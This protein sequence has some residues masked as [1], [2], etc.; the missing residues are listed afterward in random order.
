MTYSRKLA[1]FVCAL[2]YD[3]VPDATRAR[4][5][6]LMTDTLGVGLSGSRHPNFRT[7]LEGIAAIPGTTGDHPVIGSRV[8]LSAPYAALANGVACHVL[9]FDD[10]HT[11]SIVH[12]SA[13]LTPLVLALGE[14]LGLGG[15]DVLTA[16]VAGW[17][18]AARI[19]IA[20]GN[21]FHSRGFHS[22]AIAGVFGATAAA[23]RL[24]GLTPEQ[25]TNALGLCG[26]QAAGI[27][28][29]LTN[30]SSSKGYHVGWAARTAVE[31]AYLARAG[32]TGPET[33]F[34]GRNGL[35]NTHGLVA[36][37]TPQ[38]LTAD[39]GTRWETERV[40]IKP[41]PCCHFAHG[42]IDCAIALRADGVTPDRIEGIH[43]IVDE[44]AAGF[45]CKPID[46]K[47]VPSNAYGA[48]FSLPYLV[49]LGLI[50]GTVD[51]SSFSDSAIRRDDLLALA[52]K[53]TYED[54]EKGTTGFPK[55]FPGHLI[56]HLTDGRT[57]EKRVPINRGNPDAPLTDEDVAE[58]FRVNVE[59]IV[60]EA[61]AKAIVDKIASLES[62]EDISGL[63]RELVA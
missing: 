17:E 18:V 58:K 57:V 1:D 8:R 29:F 37:H 46:A 51:Q 6:Q 30:N 56:V 63:T 36:A 41:Y 13:I 45:I 31:L 27:T 14:E 15:R 49:A 28:E 2:T 48:K 26:S 9:D 24:M 34:E 54:A 3:A 59:G 44:V 4:A 12:G 50:D 55:Y 10:T 38:A 23:G 25:M 62:L 40:S 11:A 22:T 42:A 7:A 47:Y 16:F 60:P 53:L 33:V 52:R 19:G 21:S 39:L 20:S 35:M 43:A 61:R 5:R 32:A